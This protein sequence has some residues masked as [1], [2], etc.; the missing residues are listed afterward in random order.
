MMAT[1]RSATVLVSSIFVSLSLASIAQAAPSEGASTS[2]MELVAPAIGAANK[3]L[4]GNVA[5]GLGSNAGYT[6]YKGF[7][8]NPSF[9]FKY[10]LIDKLA[11]GLTARDFS[12]SSGSVGPAIEYYFQTSD[13]WAFLVGQEYSVVAARPSM[14]KNG[15]EEGDWASI[16]RLGTKYFLNSHFTVGADLTYQLRTYRL[17]NRPSN[18]SSGATAEL[19]LGYFF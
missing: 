8:T 18:W 6:S 5:V 2:E 10:F 16:T 4:K 13:R 17:A 9:N 15:Y 3:I 7:Q 12:N 14:D 19:Q 1:L 11:L